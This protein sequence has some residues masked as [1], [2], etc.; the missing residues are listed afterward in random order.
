MID[1]QEH[2]H[3]LT[4]EQGKFVLHSRH[5]KLRHDPYWTCRK[6][7]V[8]E[9]VSLRAAVSFRRSADAETSK[10]L[11]QVL[12]AHYELPRIPSLPQLDPH[13]QE[14]LRWVLSRKRSYLAHAPGA[15]KTAQ[16]IL[17]AC[18]AQGEGQTL[19]IV[20]PSLT[21]NWEREI[22]KVTE[23]LGVFPTIGG[24]SSSERRESVA[25]RAQFVI[26][27]DSMLAKPWVYARL[28][29]MKK[30]L[31]AVDEASRFKEF[32]AE[33]S[34]AFY[35]G[36][37]EKVSYPGIFR[38][39]R[40]VVFLDG[41]P[42]PN[43]PM[44]LWAPTYALHPEAI[45]CMDRDDFGYRYCGARINE[46]KVWEYLYSSHEAELRSKLQKDFMHVVAE[47]RLS[48]PERRR[49]LLFI[50]EDARS[51]EHKSWERQHLQTALKAIDEEGDE[52]GLGD[53]ARFRRELGVR[54]I[55]HIARYAAERLEKNESILLFVWHRE[56]AE[57]LAQ[58]LAHYNPALVI[59]G[60]NSVYREGAF[61]QFQA[62]ERKLIIGNIQ[63]MGRG[64]NLQRADRVLFGEYSWTDELNR[65]CE[66][67]A[68]RRGNERAFTRCEYIVSPGSMDEV[69]LQSIF[70]K[71]RRV[72]RIIG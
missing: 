5:A 56:V 15:G 54:K 47:D 18:L 48:H 20:P 12:Q 14:G 16:A 37:N 69:V 44:E 7:G 1:F 26:V 3:R 22:W 6:P 29:A 36:A 65:Q 43:R 41:S 62:G 27:P 57:T 71:Q 64:H 42:M 9:T 67:R 70:T 2:P 19:F 51:L 23:W 32:T 28:E 25:W 33:R 40:H 55:P 68:S 45:D 39:A 66:K 24:V 4:F 49:S 63:A 61:E 59:G 53:L 34:L 21:V 8:Y 11:N 35:G 60:T 30:K 13:Q 31:I 50:R 10:I 72:E 46:R 58:E 52:A 17:A 38:D